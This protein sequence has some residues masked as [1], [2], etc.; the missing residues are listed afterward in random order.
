M[1]KHAGK[2]GYQPKKYVLDT[3]SKFKTKL[4][5]KGKYLETPTVLPSPFIKG[6]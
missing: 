2:V 6:M 1:T 5:A 4:A 3:M